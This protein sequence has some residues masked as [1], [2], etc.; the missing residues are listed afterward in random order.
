MQED[1]ISKVAICEK[2]NGF[3]MACHK[4]HLNKQLEKDFTELTNEGFI[5]KFETGEE[6]R[7]RTYVDYNKCKQGLC[8]S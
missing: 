6:T 2:C 5:V 1:R 3:I 7:N 8:N 4:N